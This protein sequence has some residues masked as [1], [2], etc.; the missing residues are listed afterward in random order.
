VWFV[1]NNA[2]GAEFTR[3]PELWWNALVFFA[4]FLV[5]A[6][7]VH[8]LVALHRQLEQRVRQRT[9]ALERETAARERLQRE[10]LEAG[11]R[12]RGSIGR[13]LHDGLGQHLTA[14]AYS[15]QILAERLAARGE[16]TTADARAVV[17][18]IEEGIAQNRRIAR[19]LLLATIEPS[20]LAGE[21]AELAHA[22][23]RLARVPCQCDVHGEPLPPD[24]GA[25]THLFRI[26]QE[27]VRNALRHAKPRNL[28]IVFSGS[29][30][31]LTLTIQDDGVGLPLDAVSAPG[32]GLRIM[33]HRAEMIGAELTVERAS[34]GGTR[35]CCHLPARDGLDDV[36]L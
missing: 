8:A 28:A 4:M 20:S 10:L 26:A 18:L 13:D 24:T 21:L 19:G 3:R 16:T 1:S 25:A 33:A 29:D 35:V 6:L 22:T 9:E 11:E 30:R 7:A 5:V 34:D 32:M 23:T 14:T 17:R 12:E 36:L 2:A 15:A 27:A 31:E